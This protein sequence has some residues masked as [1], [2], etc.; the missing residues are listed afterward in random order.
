MGLRAIKE[1]AGLVLVQ[2][3]STAKF[4]SMPRSAIDAGLADLVAPAEALPGK[5]I[6]YL[7]H[8]RVIAKSE[9]PWKRRTRAP[10]ESRYPAAGQ[11]RQDFSLY[12]KNTVYRGSSGAWAFTRLT[13]SL[14]TSVIC[15]K[16]RRRWNSFSRNC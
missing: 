14:P 11:D 7:Q 10:G 5:I 15:R 4:D 3:P 9:L 6:D 8:A 16:T 13:G 2:E 1:K 12:K